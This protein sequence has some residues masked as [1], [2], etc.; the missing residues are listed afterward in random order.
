MSTCRGV[1]GQV[2]QVCTAEQMTRG[3]WVSEGWMEGGL[4]TCSASG[5]GS[6]AQ[7]ATQCRIRVKL[8]PSLEVEAWGL[9]DRKL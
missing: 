6:G 4:G 3:S 8:P 7:L 5:V 1:K 2:L 9:R